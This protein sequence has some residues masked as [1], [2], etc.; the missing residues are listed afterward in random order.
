MQI[1]SLVAPFVHLAAVFFVSP[2]FKEEDQGKNPAIVN[3]LNTKKL[4][5]LIEELKKEPKAGQVTFFSD[6]I[7]KEG[8][9]S[10]TSIGS[11]IVDGVV[12]GK[13]RKFTHMGD[14]I[15]ELGG[16]GSAPGAVEEL[17]SAIGTSIAASANA[18]A[19]LRNVKLTKI[20][21]SIKSEIN[22]RGLLGLDDKVRPGILNMETT[23]KIA[24]DAQPEVLREIALK[25]YTMSP[26]S[27]SVHFGASH[28]SPPTIL[29]E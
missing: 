20:E 18:N 28:F 23:I 11:Y 24:G 12:K 9:K 21:V 15:P 26:V 22:M 7:W 14:E 4:S 29:V 2:D 3:G 19:A 16:A 17:M 8:A 10:M 25:G 5:A 13:T 27:D 6:T 1:L